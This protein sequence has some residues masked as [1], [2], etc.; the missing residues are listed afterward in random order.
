M[1]A[2]QTATYAGDATAANDTWWDP[3]DIHKVGLQ[4]TMA[5]LPLL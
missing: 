4:A 1:L 3:T 2:S 5:E